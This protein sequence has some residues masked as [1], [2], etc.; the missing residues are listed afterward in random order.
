MGQT[1][2]LPTIG[3]GALTLERR[4][5]VQ[6]ADARLPGQLE[7][8]VAEDGNALAEVLRIKLLHL[9]YLAVL[10]PDPADRRT[11]VQ[12]RAFVEHPVEIHESLREGFWIVRKDVHDTITGDGSARGRRSLSGD[13]SCHCCDNSQRKK[14]E[15]T[16]LHRA[17]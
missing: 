14:R 5:V 11:P 1:P 13:H 7:Q 17:T 2:A 16:D 6:E 9:Q 15:R 8:R 3:E 4:A 12:A 10:D